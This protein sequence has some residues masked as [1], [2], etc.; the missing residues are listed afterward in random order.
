MI[1]GGGNM[2][3]TAN[4]R[5]FILQHDDFGNE[6]VARVNEMFKGTGVYFL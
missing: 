3:Q 4:G 1:F 6:L 2:L 5:P